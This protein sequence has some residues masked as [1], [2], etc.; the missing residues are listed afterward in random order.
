M[1]EWNPNDPDAAN[2]YYDVSAWSFEHQAELSGALADT[3]IP[4]GW[5]EQELIVPE[6][7]EQRA[8]ELFARLEARLGI[9]SDPSHDGYG[10]FASPIA[11]DDDASATEYDLAEWETLERGLVVDSLV[12]AGIPF[13][14]EDLV[15][16]VPT[17]SE[18]EVDA[19]LDDV[20]QGNV[21]AI[22]DDEDGADPFEALNGFFLGAQRLARNTQDSAGLERVLRALETADASRPPAGVE[23]GLWRKACTLAE[24]IS[25]SLIEEDGDPTQA[26]PLAQQLHDLLRP[27]I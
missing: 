24:E 3:E 17:E 14:W 23:L 11:L 15:L 1:T 7:F 16:L 22:I 10:E 8:D 13:R 9:A 19:I 18:D 12:S 27:L 20:E 26:A 25:D 5:A 2:V 4:H 21:I 6:E